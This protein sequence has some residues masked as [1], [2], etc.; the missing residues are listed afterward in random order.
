MG[1]NS[2]IQVRVDEL[3]KQQAIDVLA[4]IGLDMPAAVRMFLKRIILVGGLP[5]DIKLPKNNSL[6]VPKVPDEQTKRLDAN[7]GSDTRR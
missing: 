7:E 5:F 6:S 1:K 2:F 3:E 4:S